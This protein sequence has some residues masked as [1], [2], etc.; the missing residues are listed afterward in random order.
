MHNALPLIVEI[1]Q[2]YVCGKGRIAGSL[3]KCCAARHTGVVIP[4]R[5]CV[6]Y[7]IHRAECLFRVADLAIAGFQT[8][9][10]DAAGTFM[11]EDA[12]YIYEAGTITQISNLMFVPDFLND[13][14]RHVRFLAKVFGAIF[15]EWADCAGML[16]LDELALRASLERAKY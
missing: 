15:S 5:C 4:T 9:E 1:E 10:R 6:D 2:L 12:I 7:V 13:S 3:D 11:K 14:L 16:W 8:L